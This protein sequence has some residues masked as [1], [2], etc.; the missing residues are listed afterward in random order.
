[1]RHWH[2]SSQLFSVC[3]AIGL[4]QA[5]A[6]AQDNH[7]GALREWLR[8]TEEAANFRDKGD[9]IKAEQRL[10]MAIREIRPY[11][12]ET[13]RNLAR[14]YSELARVLYHQKRYADAEPL[15]RW[16]LSVR[17]SD[18]KAKPD[19]VFQCVYALALIQSARKQHAEAESLF[20][21]SLALQEENL[22]PDHINSNLILNQLATV[23][24]EQKKYT[25]AEP[26][27]VRSIAI[28]ERKRPTE[29]LDLAETAEK[30][31]A[32]LGLMNRTNDA[33]RW[34]ARAR[35]I[36]ETVAAKEAQA[37]ADR[38]ADQ[39]RGYR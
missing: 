15:A 14:S 36:R 23:Y 12:P 17:E 37:R 13:R 7:L 39:F 6:F 20:K 28:L 30:Y 31:A 26:L 3:L 18:A 11:L 4:G 34:N 9:Y 25:D 22:G 10:N 5:A 2:A 19:T 24:V 38:L 21:R 1:M 35:T 27:Y 32:L 16:A 8:H 29:N 33:A